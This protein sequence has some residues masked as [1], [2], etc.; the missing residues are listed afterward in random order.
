MDLRAW[1]DSFNEWMLDRDDHRPWWLSLFWTAVFCCGVAILLTVLNMA[2][3]RAAD[4]ASPVQWWQT[5]RT[6]AGISLCIGFTIH[7]LFTV[8]GRAIG[9]PRVRG[10]GPWRR[11][12]YYSLVPMTGVAVG[13]PVGVWLVLG[14]DLA[15]FTGNLS[16]RVVASS[17]LVCGVITTLFFLYFSIKHRQVTAEKQ[18]SEAQL[19]LLQA[20]IEPH[21]LFNTLANVVSLIEA[22]PARAR[23]MLE[24]FV[25]YLRA[26]LSGLGRQSHTLGDELAVV[27]AYLRVVQTRMDQ[28]LAY[29]IAV[30][31]ALRAQHLPPLS[32]QPLVENAVVHGLEPSIE[33][34]TVT[35][36]AA[37]EDGRLVVT[38]A[39]DGIGLPPAAA[40]TA[41]SRTSSSG[42]I[43]APSPSRRRHAGTGTAL[44]NIRARLQ[45]AYGGRASLALAPRTARGTMATLALP[46]EAAPA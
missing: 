5:Y 41:S 9:R 18:A 10:F 31:E 44:A 39:D 20:Q 22:D 43:E 21:F 15:T 38:V 28:R 2:A 30:P 17:L 13:W 33:G 3:S 26:S 1:G 12:A 11:F 35:V 42:G 24:S 27:E 36:R 25:D 40:G 32:I 8:V 6:H 29:V 23:T 19:R 16:P 45:Q 7:A 34:G 46:L 14:T 4:L 37:V